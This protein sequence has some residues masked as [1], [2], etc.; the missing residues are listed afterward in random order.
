[1]PLPCPMPQLHSISP[2]RTM[3]R[4]VAGHLVRPRS[5]QESGSQTPAWCSKTKAKWLGGWATL[6]SKQNEK[7]GSFPLQGW[8]SE[9]FETTTELDKCLGKGYGSTKRGNPKN[10]TQQEVVVLQIAWRV[11]SSSSIPTVTEEYS[12]I[13]PPSNFYETSNMFIWRTQKRRKMGTKELY[14]IP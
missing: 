14:I 11:S 9:I 13:L 12:N 3:G 7:I 2:G 10:I 8:K 4:R 1:M 6:F 5:M